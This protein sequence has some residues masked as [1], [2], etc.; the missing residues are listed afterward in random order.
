MGLH[1]LPP[2]NNNSKRT[3]FD[4]PAMENL[5]EPAHYAVPGGLVRCN[6]CGR[7]SNSVEEHKLHYEGE[8]VNGTNPVVVETPTVAAYDFEEL[9]PRATSVEDYHPVVEGGFNVTTPEQE[10]KIALLTRACRLGMA[11]FPDK[12]VRLEP[13]NN[14]TQEHYK[15]C[16]RPKQLLETT[17]DLRANDWKVQTGGTLSEIIAWL[18]Q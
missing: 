14:Q 4:E 11:R 18:N 9:Q 16:T 8:H 2:P 5:V 10:D 13:I 1:D 12:V 7:D 15:L 6:V 3:M 17:T